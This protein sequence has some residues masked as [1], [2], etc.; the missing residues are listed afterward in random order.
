MRYHGER[1]KEIR[2]KLNQRSNKQTTNKQVV[3]HQERKA[4]IN[5]TKSN[6]KHKQTTIS[7][8]EIK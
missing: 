2:Q 6:P 7:Q 1:K 5:T 4:N 3:N 8:S